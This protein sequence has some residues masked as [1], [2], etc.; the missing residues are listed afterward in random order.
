LGADSNKNR[1]FCCYLAAPA[2]NRRKNGNDLEI[3]RN[4]SG[5]KNGP[6]SLV[7]NAKFTIS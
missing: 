4:F 7:D 6:G 2:Q 1:L 3:I 5:R